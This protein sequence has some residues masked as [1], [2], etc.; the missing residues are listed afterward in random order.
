MPRERR[1]RKHR[2]AKSVK[3]ERKDLGSVAKDRKE[4]TS[5][6]FL[7]KE[8][9]RSSNGGDGDIGAEWGGAG[10]TGRV[11]SRWMDGKKNWCG[12]VK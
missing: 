2:L 8:L 1:Y 12:G 6:W 4:R 9:R 10:G 5:V 7:R 3:A 11:P